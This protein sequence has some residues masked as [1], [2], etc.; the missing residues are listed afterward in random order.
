MDRIA[1]FYMTVS[2]TRSREAEIPHT[3]KGTVS[4]TR[5]PIPHLEYPRLSEDTPHRV[6]FLDEQTVQTANT[7]FTTQ[8]SYTFDHWDGELG[9]TAGTNIDL[10]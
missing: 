3:E 4:G 1:P 10:Y 7:Q 6:S 5:L 8:L 9:H 2:D